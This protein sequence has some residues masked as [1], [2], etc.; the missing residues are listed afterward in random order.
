MNFFRGSEL[1]ISFALLTQRVSPDVAV[2][3]AFPRS[4][5]PS[6]CLW[7]PLVFFVSSCFLLLML[8][9]KPS[10]NKLGA[11]GIRTGALRFSWHQAPPA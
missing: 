9:T 1:P 5:V 8:L 2:T 6:S 7:I 4:A 11:A 10:L 3:D